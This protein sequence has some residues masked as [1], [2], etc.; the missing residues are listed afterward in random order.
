[1]ALMSTNHLNEDFSTCRFRGF[2]PTLSRNSY[3]IFQIIPCQLNLMMPT[4]V[5][6][7]IA[8]L[9]YLNSTKQCTYIQKTPWIVLVHTH[10]ESKQQPNKSSDTFNSVYTLD[11]K[12]VPSVQCSAH[13]RNQKTIPYNPPSLT[14]WY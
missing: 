11:P 14:P 13:L 2:L 10:C 1:M 7:K 4:T 9:V 5:V 6:S 8:L 12:L 3:R